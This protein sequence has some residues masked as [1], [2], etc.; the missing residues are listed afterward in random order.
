MVSIH[1]LAEQDPGCLLVIAPSRLTLHDSKL[2]GP[3]VKRVKTARKVIQRW[4]H[5]AF[6][7][8]FIRGAA[9]AAAGRGR[10]GRRRGA[11]AVSRS[12]GGGN[13]RRGWRAAATL[14]RSA[15]RTQKMTSPSSHCTLDPS[16]LFPGLSSA[17]PRGSPRPQDLA[18]DVHLFHQPAPARRAGPGRPREALGPARIPTP[19]PPAAPLPLE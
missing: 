6:I 2:K 9:M 10:G 4:T 15:L 19:T 12:R 5:L 11:R 1:L 18:P 7:Y 14:H 13:P 17:S 3:S 8:L 16:P